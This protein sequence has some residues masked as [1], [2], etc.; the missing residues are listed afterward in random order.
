MHHTL[1]ILQNLV[2]EQ[3]SGCQGEFLADQVLAQFPQP[4]RSDRVVSVGGGLGDLAVGKVEAFDVCK[5]SDSHQYLV[6]RRVQG[7]YKRGRTAP[8]GGL[9]EKADFVE[10]RCQF[11]VLVAA[12]V[13]LDSWQ[14]NVPSA[15]QISQFLR[16]TRARLTT[17]VDSVGGNAELGQ[18][19][20]QGEGEEDVGRLGVRVR[21][22]AV[23]PVRG[24]L[25][26]GARERLEVV[27]LGRH[28]L[29]LEVVVGE[30]DGREPVAGAGERHDAGRA[31]RTGLSGLAQERQQEVG[32]Q[33]GP[34]V[35]GAELLL[36]ALGRGLAGGDA[37]GGVVDQNVELVGQGSHVGGG[38][39]DRL[40][41]PQVKDDDFHPRA[42][43]FLLDLG[44]HLLHAGSVPR[45]ED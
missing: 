19:L 36:D 18:L 43:I 34:D 20:L 32:E 37:G 44:G 2:S 30:A 5:R 14:K 15:T 23:V 16:W 27:L 35:V 39:T 10:L 26:K 13:R 3:H 24:A 4:L 9:P 6:A 12:E 17:G 33:E 7:S 38:L 31:G 40:L 45:C 11:L 25:G 22:D 42:G 1:R 28:R 21:D 41:R 29:A 8:V